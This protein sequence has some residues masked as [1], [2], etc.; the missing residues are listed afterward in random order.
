MARTTRSRGWSAS[1]SPPGWY[2]KRRI[3]IDRHGRTR[4]TLSPGH[5]RD[6]HGGQ[7]TAA[8]RPQ[9]PGG[10]PEPD[11]PSP[12]GMAACRATSSPGLLAVWLA[13]A[14]PGMRNQRHRQSDFRC[15]Q[16]DLGRRRPS[17][18]AMR[19]RR[20]DSSSGLLPQLYSPPRPK[21][22]ENV[23]LLGGAVIQV[24]VRAPS[25]GCAGGVRILCQRADIPGRRRHD[26]EPALIWA[27]MDAEE[28]PRR[29]SNDCEVSHPVGAGRG[30]GAPVDR[31]SAAWLP[32]LLR[33]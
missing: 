11:P 32:Q 25:E 23:V 30:M 18:A 21:R 33:K 28:H 26:D 15:G 7:T 1:G 9:T 5:D 27:Q 16:G 4:H 19:A 17:V 13:P 29:A 6:H 12:L 10:G 8:V 14:T 20:S 3:D 31:L 2:R 24:A 22:P